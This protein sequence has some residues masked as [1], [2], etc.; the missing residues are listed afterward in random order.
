MRIARQ[1]PV[2]LG[3]AKRMLGA[4][5]S[6]YDQALASETE[7]ILACMETEDWAEGIR[8]FAEDR[9]PRYRGR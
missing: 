2:P 7:A 1:A 3:L 9:A 5:E 4:S 6:G 8:A